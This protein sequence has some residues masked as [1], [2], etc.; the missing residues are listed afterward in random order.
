MPPSHSDHPPEVAPCRVGVVV[1][2]PQHSGLLGPLDYLSPQPLSAGTVV[3]VP[4]GR[5]VVTGVVWDTTDEQAEPL[6]EAQLKPV[7]E[8][9]TGLP[10]LPAAWRQ[11]IQFAASYYQRSLGEMTL[12]VLP[13]ELRQL[14][15]TQWGRRLKR[16]DKLIQQTPD[17]AQAPELPTLTEQQQQ[18]LEALAAATDKPFLLWGSTGSGKTEVYL[19]Q[20]QRALDAGQQVLMMVPEINLT[21]QLEARVAER[22]AGRRIVSLHSGLTPAQRLRNWLLAHTGHADLILGTRLS[23]F[24]PMPRLGLI[25]VD[26]EHDPSYKQQDGA[27]YSARDLAVYRARLERIPVILG[28]ATPSLESWYNALPVS[29]GGAGRYVRLVMPARVGDGIMPTVRILDLTRIPKPLPGHSPPPLAAELL[30][31]I[32]QRIERGEQS[33]VLLNRR[34]YAPVLHCSDCGWKSGCPHCSAWRVFHKADRTLR[35]HHCGFT[36]RVPR[37]CPDCGN[38]DIAPVGRG[39]ERLE[40]QLAEILPQA[41]VGR[42]DADV[43]KHKGALEEQLASVHAGEVDVLVG[44]Q[45]VAKGH[46]FRR[47]T[48]VAAVNPDAA[49]FASDF[50]AAE[51]QFAL[52]MQAAGRAG[53]DAEVA[54]H[55]E[56]WIQTYHPTH[57][58]YAALRRY[59]YAD[60][61]AQ[62]LKEREMAGLPPYAS[63]AMLRAEA[64]TQEAAQHFLKQAAELTQALAD[65]QILVYP[66]VPT[67]IQ[68][69]ANV[70]RAQMMIESTHR[71]AL[72]R[73]LQAAQPIWLDEAQKNRRSGLIR[74]AVDV[75]PLAI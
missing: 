19:R 66:P 35:C 54:G 50:R 21:P 39:T 31:A 2:A 45:M 61:A 37:A 12:M 60:F 51:R 48:L 44:T 57:P 25:V 24:T 6:S 36:E 42:I 47:I 28:S 59:D 71:V 34:G 68:R 75:D 49:L 18:A 10:P 29:E 13:P 8:V 67:P 32:E 55:S 23:V 4:L 7:A 38:Q 43:T 74:W 11:L 5:R 73:F 33:L 72:L 53:R 69:V 17:A 3:R 41:R 65:T 9:L 16:L 14:D 40:E 30:H 22:F 58:L 64:K 62:Q 1:E 52:L 56:M 15:D 20:A 26:E 63:L 27:R 46:D 70:E